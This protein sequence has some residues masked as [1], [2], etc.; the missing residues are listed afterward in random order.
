[1]VRYFCAEQ[2]MREFKDASNHT[3]L[4]AVS[5]FHEIDQLEFIDVH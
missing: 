5:Q 2:S 1:M 4:C 3:D